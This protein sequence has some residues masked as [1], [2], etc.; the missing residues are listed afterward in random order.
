[1][2]VTAKLKDFRMSAKKI[3]LVTNLVKNMPVIEA[4]GQLGIL[5]KKVALPILKLLNSVI[6][7]AEN[8]FNLKKENLYIKN[9]L[10]D[11][12]QTLKRWRPRAFGRATPIRKRTAQV[13]I[14]LDEKIASVQI[15]KKIEKLEKPQL[16]ENKP[17]ESRQAL[18]V[19]EEETSAPVELDQDKSEKIVDVTRQGK[20]RHQQHLDQTKIKSSEGKIKK[21]FRRKAA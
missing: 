5:N 6:A 16:V 11:E 21:F 17:V 9:I 19:T 14:I 8:N 20:H 1:M 7:N 4:Q 15:K 13:E 3:R 18:P 10:V 2:E 12:G